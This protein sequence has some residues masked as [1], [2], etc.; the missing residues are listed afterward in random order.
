MLSH[1]LTKHNLVCDVH[2]CVTKQQCF[3]KS[4]CSD[5]TAIENIALNMSLKLPLNISFCFDIMIFMSIHIYL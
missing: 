2:I 3:P 5:N 4:F 1:Y